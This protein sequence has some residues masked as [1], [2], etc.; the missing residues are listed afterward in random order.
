YH[1]IQLD[2]ATGKVL[3]VENRRSDLVEDIHDMSVIDRLL[4]IDGVVF[5]LV[6]LGWQV[7]I[8]VLHLKITLFYSIFWITKTIQ[9][10]V[11]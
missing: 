2:G 11:K 5:Q 1:G 4:G 8:E 10:I 3:Y 6:C 9:L 7:F